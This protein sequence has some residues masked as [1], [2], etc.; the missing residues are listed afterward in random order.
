MAKGGNSVTHGTS[1]RIGKTMVFKTYK[2]KTVIS[3]YPDMSNVKTSKAQKN[4]RKLF[5][6]AVAYAKNKM[7]DPVLKEQ[8]TKKFEKKGRTAYHALIQEYFQAMKEKD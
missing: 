5:A 4:R 7:S 8:Y 3:K 2:D 6:E 1:G